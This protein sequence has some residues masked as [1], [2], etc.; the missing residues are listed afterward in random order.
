MARSLF[1][2]R[3]INDQSVPVT[4][5]SK[6]NPA[7]AN[8]PNTG[9]NLIESQAHPD[10]ERKANIMTAAMAEIAAEMNTPGESP[11]FAFRERMR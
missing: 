2:R 8:A 3:N 10:T 4:A 6:K 11:V 5:T 7:V 9:P 1:R